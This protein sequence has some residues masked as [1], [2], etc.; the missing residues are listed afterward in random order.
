MHGANHIK[1]KHLSSR[2]NGRKSLVRSVKSKSLWCLSID[3]SRVYLEKDL[4]EIQKKKVE[5]LADKLLDMNI[6]EL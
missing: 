3:R 2:R 4:S 1:M 6:F 5:M